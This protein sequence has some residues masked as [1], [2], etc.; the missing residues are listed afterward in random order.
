MS[1]REYRCSFCGKDQDSVRKLIAGQGGVFICNEC[2]R[3]CNEIIGEGDMTLPPA[4]PKPRRR[5][6]RERLGWR[7]WF[8]RKTANGAIRSTT[9]TPSPLDVVQFS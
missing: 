3:L 2:I 7:W 4:S 6:W 8:A 9:R 1:R 5:S